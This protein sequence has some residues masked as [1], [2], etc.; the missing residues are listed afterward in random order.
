MR[1]Y[2]DLVETVLIKG[3][4]RTTSVQGVGN[5]VYAGYQM[6][7]RPAEEFPLITTRSLAGRP[8]RAIIAE[9]LWFLSG[10]DNVTDLHKVGVRLWDAWATKEIC[11]QYNLPENSVGR[12]YGVQWRSWLCRN[13]QTI[14]QISRLINEIKT[15]P[16]S[17]RMKVTV[18]NPEDVVD[19]EGNEK[20]FIAPCHGDFK[21]VVADGVVDL[22]MTQRSADLPVGV[23]FNIAS[24]SL[25]LLMIAQ[26]SGLKAGEFTHH[27]QDIHIYDNQ[28]EEIKKQLALKPRPLPL[29]SLN[30]EVTDLFS[31]QVED[32]TLEGYDP[33]PF[34]K[35]P[36][37]T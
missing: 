10:S 15:Q 22:C 6:K 7:F 25:L 28:V 2:L 12:I 11:N 17:K 3:R 16:D 18:W 14:D 1:Q 29:V 24:Y 37:L 5:T 20:V 19:A 27:L 35:I 4:R 9:L 8:W 26:V 34:F 21:C 33:H 23:P 36:V 13:G 32:F 30:P 31:F